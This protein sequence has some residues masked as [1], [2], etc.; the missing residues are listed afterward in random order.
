LGASGRL[1][2]S[3]SAITPARLAQ[4]SSQKLVVHPIAR[5]LMTCSTSLPTCEFE[6]AGR[7]A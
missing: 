2:D 6:I 3:S 4:I 7:H 1:L 5:S